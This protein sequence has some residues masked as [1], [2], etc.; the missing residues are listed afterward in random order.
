MKILAVDPG[1][2]ESAWL[3]YD[4]SEARVVDWAKVPNEQTLTVVRAYPDVMEVDSFACEMI[5]SYG[6]AVGRDIFDTCVWI[7]RFIEAWGGEDYRLVYR[8]DVKLH[9]THTRRAK[10]PE[11]RQALIDLFGPDKE[12]A[13]GKKASPGPLYGLSGRWLERRSGSAVTAAETEVS[14]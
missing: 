7:G 13:I 6:M 1:N 4:T 9:L 3:V 5:A 11:I 12:H 14:A 2:T 10:D 8:A